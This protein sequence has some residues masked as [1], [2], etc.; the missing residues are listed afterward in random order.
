MA[1]SKPQQE[2][3]QEH[4]S[5]SDHTARGRFKKGNRAGVKH[6]NK[7][8]DRL[9]RLVGQEGLDD[10]LKA[11]YAA[12]LDGNVQSRQ[13]LLGRVM[14][15]IKAEAALR[16]FDL[17]L[18][19]LTSATASIMNAVAAGELPSDVAKDLLAGLNSSAQIGQLQTM[20][21]QI[22][23]LQVA[24]EQRDQPRLSNTN[25]VPGVNAP[26]T[27]TEDDWRNAAALEAPHDD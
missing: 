23:D 2:P 13:F 18:S 3:D 24:L 11:E 17:D 14:P 22:S 25:V 5:S 26:T 15:A 12:A 8:K 20:A 9:L 10:L 4:T 16:T 1:D 21:Q 6:H 27:P 7:T 19:D